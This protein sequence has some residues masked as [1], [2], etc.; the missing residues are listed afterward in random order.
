ML[1]KSSITDKLNSLDRGELL[2][3]S[4]LILVLSAGWVIA[5]DNGDTGGL[6]YV[7]ANYVPDA[8]PTVAYDWDEEEL[9]AI[10][11]AGNNANAS[12][13]CTNT[14]PQNGSEGCGG[15]CGTGGGINLEE[16]RVYV[17]RYY[18]PVLGED[19]QVDIRD[20]GCHQEVDVVKEGA[21]VKR[22]VVSGG[23]ITEI[24]G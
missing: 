22:L 2:F 3:F 16:L 9:A 23:Y 7:S 20:Y 15:G 6:G 19:I 4:G 24:G 18:A 12:P 21:V 8:V 5:Q 1:K 17:Y 11:D 14:D 10:Q 13:C